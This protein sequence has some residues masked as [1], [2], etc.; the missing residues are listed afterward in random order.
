MLRV[1][2]VLRLLHQGRPS[3]ASL[4]SALEPPVWKDSCSTS[5]SLSLGGEE[6]SLSG[7]RWA[8]KKAGGTAKQK[9]DSKGKSLGVKMFSGQV[10]FPGQ[11]V[12]RQRGTRYRPGYNVGI[13]RDHTIFATTVGTVKFTDEAV[14]MGDKVEEKK[15]VNV[16]PLNNDWSPGYKEQVAE[17]VA[18]RALIKRQML[19]GRAFEPALFFSMRAPQHEAPRK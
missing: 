13:G 19:K 9:K 16:V 2:A 18:R 1:P 10:I 7:L 17:M 8:T 12:V 15:F 6:T 5:Y 11:I 4:L 3:A 14:K